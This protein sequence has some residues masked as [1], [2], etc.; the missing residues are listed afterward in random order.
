[1][2]HKKM[3]NDLQYL[4]MYMYKQLHNRQLDCIFTTQETIILHVLHSN[5]CRTLYSLV[6]L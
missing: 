6:L 2:A 1:M 4:M 3:R 5:V